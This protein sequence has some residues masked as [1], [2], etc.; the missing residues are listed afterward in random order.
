[1]HITHDF[2]H[3]NI[4]FHFFEDFFRLRISR[5]KKAGLSADNPA[6]LLNFLP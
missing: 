2:N 6:L 5:T 3:V 4:F 1:L